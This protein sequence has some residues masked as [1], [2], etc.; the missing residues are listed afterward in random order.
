MSC[1]LKPTFFREE[2]LALSLIRLGKA[3][4][5]VRDL[6]LVKMIKTLNNVLLIL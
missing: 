5:F 3:T 1:A 2:G 4:F 6:L